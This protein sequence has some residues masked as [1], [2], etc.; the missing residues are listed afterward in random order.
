MGN[1]QE[2]VRWVQKS[3]HD[4]PGMVWANRLLATAAAH[5]G[6]LDLARSAVQRLLTAHPDLTIRQVIGAIHNIDGAHLDLYPLGLWLAGLPEYSKSPAAGI[7]PAPA[8]AS[9]PLFA[10]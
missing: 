3:L 7:A 4:R 10:E 8:L 6:D 5:A 9:P 1:F 2:C